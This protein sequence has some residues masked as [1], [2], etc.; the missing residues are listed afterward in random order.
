M[1]GF[2]KLGFGVDINSLS[3]N[4][5]GAEASF[6]MAFDTAN[7]IILWRYLDFSWKLKRYFNILSEATMKEN[8]KTVDDFVYK[9]IHRR[10][11]E[12]SFHNSYVREYAHQ[13]LF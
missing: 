8:I 10:R 12:I 1:D 6:A 4:N 9:V 3:N 11:Q 2:C 13:P 5:S 7:A